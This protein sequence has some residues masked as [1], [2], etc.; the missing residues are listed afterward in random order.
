MNEADMIAALERSLKLDALNDQIIDNLNQQLK[1][2][3]KRIAHLE[4]LVSDCADYFEPLID[5]EYFTDRA[6]PVGNKEMNL[7][8]SIKEI[9][10]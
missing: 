9:V 3:K 2:A 8:S 7:Y 4:Q 10:P 5:A 6:A 1:L